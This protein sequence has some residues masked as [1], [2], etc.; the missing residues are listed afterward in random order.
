M[1]KT[2]RVKRMKRAK[3]T[4]KNNRM[5]RT[6]KGGNYKYDID[7]STNS[8]FIY[9]TL[10]TTPKIIYKIDLP[11][12]TFSKYRFESGSYPLDQKQ[13]PTLFRILSKEKR[14]NPIVDNLL[15]QHGIHNV[16]YQLIEPTFSRPSSKS[17][18]SRDF[19]SDKIKQKQ[20]NTFKQ[21]MHPIEEVDE[22]EEVE[23]IKSPIKSPES[24]ASSPSVNISARLALNS[25]SPSRPGSISISNPSIPILT[26]SG[27]SISISNGDCCLASSA[28]P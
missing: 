26:A 2:N 25:S 21:E 12:K 7:I 3:I 5:R 6:Q 24:S 14:I 17:I 8:E 9:I 10:R 27:F 1:R 22:V 15:T 13:D 20:V 11:Y 23:E 28:I 18:S 4:K 19:A 16:L